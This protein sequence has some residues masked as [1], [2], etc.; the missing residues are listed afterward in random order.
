MDSIDNWPDAFDKPLDA[1]DSRLDAIDKS[2]DAFDSRLDSID[3]PLDAFDSR[4][5]SSKGRNDRWEE[6]RR[7]LRPWQSLQQNSQL[8]Y[9][10]QSVMTKCIVLKA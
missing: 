5:V 10:L 3:K 9:L 4:K 6:A 2:L 8:L 7:Y 1:F